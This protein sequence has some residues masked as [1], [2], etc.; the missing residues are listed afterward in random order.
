MQWMGRL[1]QSGRRVAAPPRKPTAS[2]IPVFFEE[3]SPW[4]VP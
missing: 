2:A 1:G 4:G 3:I